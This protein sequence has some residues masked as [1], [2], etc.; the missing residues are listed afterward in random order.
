MNDKINTK[1]EFVVGSVHVSLAYYSLW[2]FGNVNEHFMFII[3]YLRTIRWEHGN[4]R[5]TIADVH[6]S[7]TSH[8]HTD[9]LPWKCMIH[10]VHAHAQCIKVKFYYSFFKVNKPL[11]IQSYESDTLFRVSS[12]VFYILLCLMDNRWMNTIKIQQNNYNNHKAHLFW[13]I[14]KVWQIQIFQEEEL[15]EKRKK[16]WSKNRFLLQK[17]VKFWEIRRVKM[18]LNQFL[19]EA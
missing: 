7:H 6:V 19:A 8:T 1:K 2:L 15:E 4:H 18:S 17:W 11:S 16:G 10:S 5:R 14:P 3:I 12:T 13:W 9:F